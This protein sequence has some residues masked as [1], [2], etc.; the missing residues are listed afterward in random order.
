MPSFIVRRLSVSKD[1]SALGGS[2]VMVTAAGAAE[3]KAQGA[4]QL[5]CSPGELIATP[6]ASDAWEALKSE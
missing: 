3:A 2:Q 1:G 6:Y 4:T 5:G